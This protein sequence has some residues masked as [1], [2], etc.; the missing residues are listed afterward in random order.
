MTACSP[1]GTDKYEKN[2]P[3]KRLVTSL[4]AQ[5]PAPSGKW[6]DR[7]RQDMVQFKTR[8]W[9][10]DDEAIAP[11]LEKWQ[12]AVDLMTELLGA[13]AGFVVEY[14]D[15]IG[16]RSVV[17][18]QNNANPYAGCKTSITGLDTNIFCRQVIAQSDTFYEPDARGKAEWADNPELTEDG[19]CSYFG[20]PVTWSNGTIFGTICVFDR[21]PTRY[22]DTLQKLI[23]TIRDLIEADLRLYEQ[24]QI[25]RSISLSD[26]LT[27]LNNRAG[28]EMLAQQKIRIAKRYHHHIGL[29]FID[30]DDMKH[31]NDDYGHAAGDAALK[32]VGAAIT[33]SIREVDICGRI[34]GDEFAILGYVRNRGDLTTII[35]RIRNALLAVKLTVA[36]SKKPIHETPKISAGAAVFF[37]PVKESLETMM[38]MADQ[39]MYRDKNRKR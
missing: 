31:W 24:F 26:Q 25:M 2:G 23:E 13:T 21:E 32:A 7:E 27:G 16:Y 28:F 34:G 22:S 38:D 37:E 1:H 8:D 5:R 12:R 14:N 4:G 19:F 3:L 17:T 20:V 33:A 39:E 10:V 35:T 18:S 9:L 30:L 11:S 6:R 29:I 36:A 15:R